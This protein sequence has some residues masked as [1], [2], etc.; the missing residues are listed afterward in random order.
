MVTVAGR[1]EP[2]D[3]TEIARRPLAADDCALIVVDMQEKLLP[4]IFNKEQMVANS[5]LLI[6]LAQLLDIPVL[7]TTQYTKGLGPV[8]AEIA[9]LV[10][11]AAPI[12]KMEFSCFGNDAFCSAVKALPG[13]RNT[14]LFCGMEAHIC[15]LQ[16]ALAALNNGYLAHVASD[17]IGSRAVWNW[18]VALD[19]MRSA[20]CVISSTEMML[21]EL[22]R[23]SGT[24]VFKQ[25]LAY[26]R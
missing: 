8:I 5:Q 23:R 18:R 7:L 21:Y 3:T 4:P 11:G 9:A 1:I 16:T 12:E 24:P 10:P 26:L 25:I 6:R 17:A 20:G 19:R 14:L 2:L 15:V 22:M 13:Q